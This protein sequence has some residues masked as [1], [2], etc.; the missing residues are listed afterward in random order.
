MQLAEE[1]PKP[2]SRKLK[3]STRASAAGA[4]DL[5][6][7]YNIHE[8]EYVATKVGLVHTY[9]AKVMKTFAVPEDT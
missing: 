5:P 8:I 6:A 7:S 4:I 1:G 3:Y 2:F 9:Q